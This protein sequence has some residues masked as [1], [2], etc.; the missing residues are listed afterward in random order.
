[1][2]IDEKRTRRLLRSSTLYLGLVALFIAGCLLEPSFMKLEN[3]RDVLQRIS[4]NGILAVGMT[5][6]ILTA[7]IDLS[8]GSLLSLCSVLCAM[9]VMGRTWNRGNALAVA[10]VVTVAFCAGARLAWKICS[11]RVSRTSLRAVLCLVA[12]LALACVVG[13]WGRGQV[14]GGFG[15]W[16]VLVFVPAVGAL[17]GSLNG[18]VIARG[19][20]QPFIVT[21]AMM[22]LAV[23]LAKYIAGR[24][25][26]IHAVYVLSAEEQASAEGLQRLHRQLQQEGKGYASEAFAGLGKSLLGIRSWNRRLD[27]YERVSL[28]PIPG[29]F[30]L[31]CA[32]VAH[33]VLTRL[34][35]GR[36]IYAVGGNE[37]ATRLS[38]IDIGR[39]K[40]M[41]YM[42]SGMMAGL[43]A[44][45]YCAMYG[46]GKPDAGQMGELD[47]IAAVVIGG[48]SLMGGRGRVAGTVVGVLIFGYLGN[49]LVLKGIS[50]EVQDIIKGV[51]IVLAVLLQEGR[52]A[53]WS[54]QVWIRMN[55]RKDAS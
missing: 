2:A 11:R 36:H 43:A 48:T 44:V 15:V 12:G 27:R 41:V 10:C 6:V 51:I 8:V 38:G 26:Q 16:A 54:R 52:M 47:A 35:V 7:G 39:V 4:I 53:E 18:F 33:L 14:D 40:I 17:L 1:M 20:L 32:I 49:I 13:A 55:P 37:E 23:G 22:I 31:A 42:I 28:V 29:L 24:G 50:S 34:P 19:R 3:Q 5:L 9:M 21:L 45:L 25:G 46:Q 30:F